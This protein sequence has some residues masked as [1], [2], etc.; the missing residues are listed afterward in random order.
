MEMKAEGSGSLIRLRVTGNSH[1]QESSIT[2][3]KEMMALR[4][5]RHAPR[6]KMRVIRHPTGPAMIIDGDIT[7]YALGHQLALGLIRADELPSP[8]FELDVHL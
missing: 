5:T 3:L 2:S 7:E 8:D 6:K 1:T 4:L